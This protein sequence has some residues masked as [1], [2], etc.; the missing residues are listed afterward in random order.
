M[1]TVSRR[2]IGLSCVERDAMKEFGLFGDEIDGLNVSME[3]F[4]VRGSV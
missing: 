2:Q 1:W 3:T 4:Q